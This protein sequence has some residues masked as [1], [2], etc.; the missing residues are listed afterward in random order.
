MSDRASIAQEAHA[1]IAALSQQII[2]SHEQTH[3]LMQVQ[4]DSVNKNFDRVFETMAEVK[5]D[6]TI[7]NTTIR[8]E[9][10]ANRKLAD[11]R[12]E[13]IVK[14]LWMGAGILAALEA[15]AQLWFGKK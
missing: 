12:H 11:D 3:K 8:E 1:A 15:V 9:V 2:S 13:G 7:D 5:K 4:F 6:L 14:R 10:E